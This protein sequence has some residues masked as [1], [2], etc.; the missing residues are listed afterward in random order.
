MRKRVVK[1]KD[2][3]AKRWHVIVVLE[4]LELPT[5][6]FELIAKSLDVFSVD[7]ANPVDC[8]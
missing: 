8:L 7:F 2:N 5:S 6:C 1:E 4:L 3:V